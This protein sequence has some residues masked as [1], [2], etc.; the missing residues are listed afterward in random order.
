MCSHYEAPENERL[1]TGFGVAPETQ[2][3]LDLWPLYQG[4]FIRN[5]SEAESDDQTP[6]LEALTG[7]FGLLPF[8]AK[9]RKFGRHSYNCRSETGST[10]PTFKSAWK[11]N[12]KCIIP[13]AAFFEPD[14][15]S[16]KA[17]PTRITRKDR[18][19]LAIAGLWER[20][21]EPGGEIVHSYTMLTINADSHPFMKDFHKPGD[22]K[23]SI[24]I[25]P[26]G[27]IKDWLN[28]SVEQTM[29]FMQPYPPERLMVDNRKG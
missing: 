15:R 16:G 27:L 18:G 4:P 14:W 13:V 8:W 17:I 6:E 1:L 3:P 26:N 19:V 2:F 29:S 20:W 12:Q 21:E 22:E 5:R 7:Q 10:K 24:V 11:K 23:R 9:D 25:L 28:S